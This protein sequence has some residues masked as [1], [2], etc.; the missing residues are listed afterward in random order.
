[1]RLITI[2]MFP[3]ACC[4]PVAAQTPRIDKSELV[5]AWKLVRV[6]ALR[7]D[8]RTFLPLG[9][10][11]M[12]TLAYLASGD[13]VVAW[14]RE[15]RPAPKDPSAPTDGE[16]RA[17][18]ENYFNAYFGTFQLD[19]A[20]GKISHR[21]NGTLQ[22]GRSGRTVVRDIEL[23]GDTLVLTQ[24]PGPCDRAFADKCTEGESIRLRL[25][26]SRSR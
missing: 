4:W 24:P 17:M 6:D 8:G 11:V 23:R 1:V 3:L 9:E 15:D 12:G 19:D 25:T 22:P 16:Y 5:G 14:G 18:V 20:A 13:M 26:W 21:Q 2:L 7:S 10:H